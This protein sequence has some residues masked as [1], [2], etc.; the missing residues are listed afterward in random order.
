MHA[1]TTYTWLGIQ[2]TKFSHEIQHTNDKSVS[3]CSMTSSACP[4]KN[5]YTWISI[6][7]TFQNNSHIE[8]WTNLTWVPNIHMYL[9]IIQKQMWLMIS[10]K[11]LI[12][13]KIKRFQNHT[14]IIDSKQ[15]KQTLLLIRPC[16]S[17]L[18]RSKMV[19]QENQ[20]YYIANRYKILL[21]Q[22]LHW[23]ADIHLACWTLWSCW[24]II[25][26]QPRTC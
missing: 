13:P 22:F 15:W 6:N 10:S 16:A 14:S 5:I 9:T 3:T 20:V 8:H 24:P 21:L 1:K 12:L 2:P 25:Q 4:N 11:F 19:S 26:Y 17:R 7:F 18:I 23:Q